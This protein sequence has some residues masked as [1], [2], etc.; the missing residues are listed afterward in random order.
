MLQWAFTGLFILPAINWIASGSVLEAWRPTHQ[1]W[2]LATSLNGICL[3]VL[4]VGYLWLGAVQRGPGA[5]E[6]TTV[7]VPST[8][9]AAAW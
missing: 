4:F 9:G 1:A 7:P 5:A 6:A 8:G 2:L 3:A